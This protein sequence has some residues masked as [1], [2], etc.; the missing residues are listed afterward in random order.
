VA[1]VDWVILCERAVIE[2]PPGGTISLAAI[3]ESVTMP[4]PPPEIT[5]KGQLIGIPFRFYVVQ[6]WVRAQPKISE[7]APARLLLKLPNGKEFG[8]AEFT[9]D[10]TAAPKA[11]VI[12]QVSGFPLAGEGTY[13]CLVQVKRGKGWRTLRETEFN[14]VFLA[15]PT[16]GQKAPTRH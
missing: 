10:L 3:L 15:V 9:V 5:Q 16:K 14:V 1:K 6:Q 12:S 13:R 11:R 7:R 8:L 2:A 4:A